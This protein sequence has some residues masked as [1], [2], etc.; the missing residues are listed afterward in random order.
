MDIGQFSLAGF[1]R[2][3]YDHN[4]IDLNG[5]KAKVYNKVSGQYVIVENTKYSTQWNLDELTAEN[6]FA[7]VPQANGNGDFYTI[8]LT[9]DNTKL[10]E[11]I[12]KK[13]GIPYRKNIISCLI[14]QLRCYVNT[15]ENNN[16]KIVMRLSVPVKYNMNPEKRTF[17]HLFAFQEANILWM[18][19]QEL[20]KDT[21]EFTW[22]NQER[23]Y[24]L[25]T[26]Y[27][28]SF[29]DRFCTENELVSERY[30]FCGG[31]LTDEMGCGK[32]A[33]IATLAL[34]TRPKK[35]EAGKITANNRLFSR[36]TLVI[37]P[38]H[39]CKQWKTEI[40]KFNVKQKKINII[41]ISNNAEYLA[42]KNRD[43][44]TADFVIIPYQFLFTKT[45][46]EKAE[47]IYNKYR[48]NYRFN[49]LKYHEVTRVLNNYFAENIANAKLLDMPFNIFLFEWNRI[50]LDEFQQIMQDTSYDGRKKFLYNIV[51]RYRWCVSGTPFL[52]N[53]CLIEIMNFIS[54]RSNPPI[55]NYLMISEVTKKFKLF[56]R[57]TKESTL[58]ETNLNK[59]RINYTNTFID[60]TQDERLAYEANKEGGKSELFLRQF[61]CCPFVPDILTN[62]R[63]FDDIIKEMKKFFI[64][65]REKV[66]IEYNKVCQ[67][68]DVYKS[69]LDNAQTVQNAPQALINNLN[70]HLNRLQP[71]KDKLHAE[72]TRIE[73]SL[74][75][76]EKVND[77][78]KNNAEMECPIC[79][80]P[81]ETEAK[82]AMTK[83]G[84]MFCTECIHQVRN[85]TAN[86]KCPTCRIVLNDNEIYM[87]S[88]KP[89][90]KEED[91]A[92]ANEREK[93]Y[94][95]VGSKVA[96][97]ILKIK[98]LIQD[99]NNNIIIFSEWESVLVRI[100][101]TMESKGIKSVVC[102]G[103]K[104]VRESAIRKFNQE[105]YQVIML[106]SQYASHGTNLTRANKIIFINPSPK[107]IRKDIEDQAIAR[108]YRLGQQRNIDVIRFVIKDT[109]EENI[110]NNGV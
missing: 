46:T 5:K 23:Y 84:H 82:I 52:I 17:P 3:V 58:A 65:S 66:R 16:S 67:D 97:I 6:G 70:G 77:Q 40:E 39:I 90:V 74:N 61:C 107:D 21:R 73:S 60:F 88:N 44:L 43:I 11:I 34:S 29:E 2:E 89:P 12:K 15:L 71:I 108:A 110:I 36:A 68:Y 8:Y 86:K 54:E 18:R 75:Y 98:D 22:I 9:I 53:T 30:K 32:T 1:D 50:V 41:T 109:I 72:L 57:N 59:I 28:D 51:S 96:E 38:N 79:F 101:R 85:E 24:K 69:Q 42:V 76:Y 10:E 25:N 49:F 95:E 104:L 19:K 78:F 37:I 103:N 56:R 26:L 45:I 13:E 31:A 14:Y 48:T 63:N 106:S 33:C 102:K 93:L 7:L 92:K 100:R 94:Q 47:E 55:V 83:C 62:C 91:K 4:L 87:I 27:Y 105:G 35:E 81:L 99:K 64:N 80:L 20:A